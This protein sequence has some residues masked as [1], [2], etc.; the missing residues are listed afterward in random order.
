[1]V[2]IFLSQSSEMSG[3]GS[4]WG[5]DKMSSTNAFTSILQVSVAKSFSS[6]LIKFV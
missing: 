4:I 2:N 5:S 6:N 1:V 3:C